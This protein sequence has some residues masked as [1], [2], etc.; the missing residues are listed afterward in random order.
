MYS[1]D[2]SQYPSVSVVFKALTNMSQEEMVCPDL[3]WLNGSEP[4]DLEME[5]LLEI[6]STNSFKWF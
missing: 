3:F 4:Y 6:I 5:G 2:N 1:D